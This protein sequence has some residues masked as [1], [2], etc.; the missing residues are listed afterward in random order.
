[1]D[2]NVSENSSKL[3]NFIGKIKK[4]F[5]II[6]VFVSILLLIFL[7]LLYQ[8]EAKEK[9]AIKISNEFNVARLLIEKG[10]P[11]DAKEIFYQIID[12]K[13]KFYSPLSLYLIIENNMEENKDKI[14]ISFDK[15]IKIKGLEK[16]NKNLIKIKKALFLIEK[17]A[18]EQKIL[19]ELNPI[20]NSNSIWKKE[21][22]EIIGDYFLSKGDKLKSEEFYKLLENNEN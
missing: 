11:N 12:K 21:S 1:M 18:N 16:E 20:I 19:N 2:L 8:R 5:K 10:E 13:N 4:N 22:I 14:L 3:D 7:F 9:Q 15:I 6:I 17:N